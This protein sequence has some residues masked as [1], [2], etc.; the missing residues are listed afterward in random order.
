MNLLEVLPLL[1][2]M[3]G[4]MATVAQ[5]AWMRTDAPH[6]QRLHRI[7]AGLALAAAASTFTT[8]LIL[9]VSGQVQYQYV[10]LY[11]RL[12]LGL[13][14]KIA[15]TWAGR[16]GSLL[17][18]TLYLTA[19]LV[20]LV[21]RSDRASG[22]QEEMRARAWTNLWF[23]AITTA[24]L[25]AIWSADLFARTPEF[26]L[27]GRPQ[28]NGLNPTLAS[29]FMLIHPPIMFLAYA[30]TT[31]PAAAV[32][33]HLASGTDRWSTVGLGPSRLNWLVYTLAMGLG[34]IWAYYT[35]GFG[36]FWAWDPV[37]VAN[38]LP[39]LALTL[40]LH[41][42]LHHLRHGRYRV[43]GPFLGLLPLLLTLFSTI[44]TRSGLWISVHAFTDPTQTFNPDA[45]GRFL[46]ILLT[47]NSLQ[48][49]VAMLLGILLIGLALWSR[50]LA[51][52][53]D[54]LPRVAQGVA[55]VL[56][57][58]GVLA[59]LAPATATSL[60][61]E[62][63]Y[64]LGR[65]RTGFGLLG[66]GVV[67]ILGAAAPALASEEEPDPRRTGLRRLDPKGLAYASILILGLG[68]LV[69]FLFHVAASNGW[70]ESF[71]TA[72]FP[73]LV[74]PVTVGLLLWLAYP[75]H[76]RRRAVQIAI[77][78]LL[79]AG[80][81]ALLL[82]SH[83]EGVFVLALTVPALVL[84]LDRVRRLALAPRTPR[85]L[86]VGRSLLWTAALLAVLFWL[87]PPSR[88][89]IG[90]LSW[91]PVWPAQ[92]LFGAAAFYSL[93]RTE[94]LMTGTDTHPGRTH[95]LVGALA[96]FGIGAILA[97]ISWALHRKHRGRQPSPKNPQ[98]QLRQVALMGA[99]VAV[100]LVLVGYTVSTYFGAEE[101]LTL[102]LGDTA[103]VGGQDLTFT[104]LRS[105]EEGPFVAALHPQIEV[106]GL[107]T[108]EGTLYWEPQTG[109]HYPLPE[110]VRAWWGDVYFA[111]DGL[112]MDETGNCTT[113]SD[114]VRAYDPSNRLPS[115]TESA[116]QVQLQVFT[117]PGL[118][119]VWASLFLFVYWM[120]LLMATPEPPG[121][122]SDAP[123]TQPLS[124]GKHTPRS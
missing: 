63:S 37:E 45:P 7:G 41:A 12:D 100:L 33:G 60:L 71:Y 73:W 42:Q 117:L 52:Q 36:G 53:V 48:F 124:P 11:T 69:L 13:G 15:G 51:H 35:L 111:V 28:G 119:L 95:L 17:L 62:A 68:L 44:S 9:F 106:A 26:F 67:A 81:A 56:G 59:L 10:F 21:R 72:R 110:T 34:G 40:F 118:G 120:G 80:L 5:A 98:H 30:L 94:R 38:L 31:V 27:E 86:A 25:A 75:V 97:A 91:H 76:G 85:P 112:C 24:F 14:Y 90:A 39:W 20:W 18:W 49:Y 74:A 19:I 121:P 107:G 92:L 2:L 54:R 47:E 16:E 101:E 109:S 88:V 105:V 115:G 29:P 6:W 116:S 96:A 83:R 50:R 70:S 84:G 82:P 114:W 61:F 99:H 43:V 104:G 113:D 3:G 8:L 123:P 23:A 4:L 87:N 64:A 93:H 22:D 57:A 108:G 58:L 122:R 65:G 77:A 103:T 79:L 32:L 102:D 89:G 55:L 78:T 1:G 46:D 66:L